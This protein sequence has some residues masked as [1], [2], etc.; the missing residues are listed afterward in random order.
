MHRIDGA[1]NV[2]GTW[3]A[4]DPATNRPPTEITA[5]FMNALQEELAAVIE[6]AGVQLAKADNTQL[7]EALAATFA[8]L[9]GAAFTSIPTAPAAPRFDNSEKLV[10]SAFLKA[11]GLLYA[12]AQIAIVAARNLAATDIGSH[13]LFQATTT[14]TVPT[15]ASLGMRNGDAVTISGYGGYSGTV[16]FA[17]ATYTYDVAGKTAAITVKSG[18]SLV[19]IAAGATTWQVGPSTAGMGVIGSFGGSMGSSGWQPLPGGLIFQWG[20]A[21]FTAA[22][23][24]TAFSLPVAYPNNHFTVLLTGDYTVGSGTQSYYNATPNGSKST[25]IARC[26]PNAVGARFYSIGN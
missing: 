10:N 12:N 22:N 2:N 13:L 17:G 16:A 23:A 9:S 15:P 3:V 19:L 6:W 21:S 25:F 5:A 18:E 7:R 1:G 24:D 4:E 20:T 26:T 11:S 14:L 8:Q